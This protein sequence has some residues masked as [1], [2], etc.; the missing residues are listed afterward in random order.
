MR[1]VFAGTPDAAVPSL[2]ALVAADHDVALVITRPDAPL[3]RRRILTSSPVATAASALG[4]PVHRTARLD[5]DA[6]ARV[7][8]VDPDLGV[9]VAYGGLVREP[10]LSTPRH[11]WI[12]LH[13][14]VLPR[15]RG[16][17]PVQH[18]IIAGDP[19]IGADVF[20]LTPGLDEGDIYGEVRLARPADATAGELLAT[21]A[22]AGADLVTTVVRD[23]A[24]GTAKPR[25]QQGE[26]TYAPKLSI[27]DGRVDWAQPQERVLSRILG[28]TPEP[29]AF[30]TADGS[31][32]KVLAAAPAPSDSP[33]PRPGLVTSHGKHVLVGT[34]T[35]PLA[36][37]RVQP[38]GKP[39][40][41]AGDWWRGTRMTELQLDTVADSMRRSAE[42]GKGGERA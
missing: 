34:A 5:E 16:A 10:L 24:D 2:R 31:R 39:A 7:R 27:E 28:V 15:W 33:Q 14:S 4:L 13:F 38:A 29:G 1:I 6:L 42:L 9:I 23:I 25:P 19:D 35:D 40:M 17:A 18:A 32:L 11:G 30:A 22:D 20:Q 8:E 12:N 41:D 3:G 36:L 21:L 26:P 37:L